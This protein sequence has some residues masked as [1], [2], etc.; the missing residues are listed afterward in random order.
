LQRNVLWSYCV[1]GDD[2]VREKLLKA[3]TEHLRGSDDLAAFEPAVTYL[4]TTGGDTSNISS[5]SGIGEAL[6]SY[7]IAHP[8][9]LVEG[10]YKLHEKL[11]E[12]YAIT[13]TS[14][15]LA[16]ALV[17]CASTFPG[18]RD[19]LRRLLLDDP[20]LDKTAALAQVYRLFNEVPEADMLLSL[21]N[22]HSQVRADSPFAPLLAQWVKALHEHG[23]SDML[24]RA[25]FQVMALQQETQGDGYDEMRNVLRERLHGAKFPLEARYALEQRTTDGDLTDLGREVL[26]AA[27]ACPQINDVRSIFGESLAR[28]PEADRQSEAVHKLARVFEDGCLQ[29]FI[30]QAQSPYALQTFALGETETERAILFHG[31]VEAIGKRAGNVFAQAILA[32]LNPNSEAVT[33]V[34]DDVTALLTEYAVDENRLLSFF[35]QDEIKQWEKQYGKRRL[36]AAFA[37]VEIVGDAYRHLT[38]TDSNPESLMNVLPTDVLQQIRKTLRSRTQ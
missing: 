23:Q 37:D 3:L 10:G 27:A 15:A 31:E 16:A 11:L 21:A 14:K 25:A 36:H 30:R 22:A 20:Q 17:E 13:P 1:V 24:E 19:H 29:A 9:H 6:I 38:A 7:L 8:L 34:R 26:V 12:A 5:T 4:A 33:A 28:L 32:G 2:T 18:W 35:P